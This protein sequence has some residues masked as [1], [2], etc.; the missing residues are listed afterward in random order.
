MLQNRLELV[1]SRREIKKAVA[2]GA[3]F[4]VDFVETFRQ[5]LVAGLVSEL[6]LMIEDRLR[7]RLPDFIA[8]SLAR[9]LA[10]RFFQFTPELVV[11]FFSTR[12][13][14]DC[15]RWREI[16][17]GRQIVKGGNEF[18]VGEIAGG[19]EDHNG[20]RLRHGARG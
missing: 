3:G 17:I 19:A 12:E 8:H 1:G 6:A 18:A 16:T 11:S 20:A 5:R 7:K 13:P 9:K 14:D 15:H 4:V 10:S 2:A